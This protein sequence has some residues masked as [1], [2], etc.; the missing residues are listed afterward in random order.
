MNFSRELLKLP[1]SPNLFNVL[2]L[3]A[4]NP[5]S[6]ERLYLKMLDVKEG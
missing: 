4:Q 5:V 1:Y 2:M 6:A 3:Y